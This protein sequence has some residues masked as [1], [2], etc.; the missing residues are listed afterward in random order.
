MANGLWFRS[1][2]HLEAD[3]EMQNYTPAGEET[4]KRSLNLIQRKFLGISPAA[5]T[6]NSCVGNIEVLGRPKAAPAT[7]DVEEPQAASA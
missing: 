7:S 5:A 2:V 6:T 3:A 4:S 1:L